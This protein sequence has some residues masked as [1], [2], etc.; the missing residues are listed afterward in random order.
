MT[1]PVNLSTL[2]VER[3]R[4]LDRKCERLLKVEIDRER[5]GEEYP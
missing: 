5:C 4:L 3:L 2:S 1:L